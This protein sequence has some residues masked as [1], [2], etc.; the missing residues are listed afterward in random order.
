M[1]LDNFRRHDLRS[2]AAST[3]FGELLFEVG[4]NADTVVGTEPRIKITTYDIYT[5]A[6]AYARDTISAIWLTG[7][8]ITQQP[9]SS[10]W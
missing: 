4:N 2:L 9:Q 6:G 8:A 7:A 3:P 1:A 10:F 5:M